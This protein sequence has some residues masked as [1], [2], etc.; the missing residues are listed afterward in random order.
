MWSKCANH[1]TL[2]QQIDRPAKCIMFLSGICCVCSALIFCEMLKYD[3]VFF[4]YQ[5]YISNHQLLVP[6]NFLTRTFAAHATTIN[7]HTAHITLYSYHHLSHTS[8]TQ[9]P[10]HFSTYNLI[11]TFSHKF[12]L[13]ISCISFCPVLELIYL[14]V[15]KMCTKYNFWNKFIFLQEILVFFHG[16]I[17]LIIKTMFSM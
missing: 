10:Q 9:L 16:T 7:V 3:F 8:V 1:Y 4:I 14:T 15:C 2:G 17:M 6:N 13:L 12:S 11:I 5:N